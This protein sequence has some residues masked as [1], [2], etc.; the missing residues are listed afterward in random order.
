MGTL[1]WVIWWTT[2]TGVNK[3][4]IW[5]MSQG[6]FNLASIDFVLTCFCYLWINIH[7]KRQNVD[8]S[9]E[10]SQIFWICQLRLDSVSC[11]TSKICCLHHKETVHIISMRSNFGQAF[12]S[13]L[14]EIF[15][16][17]VNNPVV[18]TGQRT[19]SLWQECIIQPSRMALVEWSKL[20]LL[21]LKITG[22]NDE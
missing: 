15:W 22:G 2:S 8:V 10:N 3:A 4:N 17:C 7:H 13:F 11:I 19:D 20:W 9:S 1:L 21:N 14:L 18:W 6:P 16:G 5:S 12:C